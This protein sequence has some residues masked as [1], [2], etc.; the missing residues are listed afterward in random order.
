MTRFGI[1]GDGGSSGTW[2]GDVDWRLDDDTRLH[3]EQGRPA[4]PTSREIVSKRTAVSAAR[5][6]RDAS[7]HPVTSIPKGK[8]LEAYVNKKVSVNLTSTVSA[9][10]G[11]YYIPKLDGGYGHNEDRLHGTH[12]MS[13]ALTAN[14]G[15]EGEPLH[16]AL[17]T[18]FELARVY[19]GSRGERRELQV[20]GKLPTRSGRILE[21][22]EPCDVQEVEQ[23]SFVFHD[24]ASAYDGA[25]RLRDAAEDLGIASFAEGGKVYFTGHPASFSWSYRVF[26]KRFLSQIQSLGGGA[27]VYERKRSTARSA[28]EPVRGSRSD[29]G[30]GAL[31]NHAMSDRLFGTPHGFSPELLATLRSFGAEAMNPNNLLV[32]R[33][34]RAS[35]ATSFVDSNCVGIEVSA[36]REPLLESFFTRGS[37]ESILPQEKLLNVGVCRKDDSTFLIVIYLPGASFALRRFAALAVSSADVA[38]LQFDYRRLIGGKL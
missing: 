1:D 30:S 16:V 21:D 6:Y 25:D 5:A 11:N 10:D 15:L 31:R 7:L 17:G 12:L 22:A 37:F 23:V 20:T 24:Q 14:L 26:E 36:D 18:R 2:D 29:S 4:P 27:P 34:N 13:G 8:D 19:R 32:Q 9:V 35:P 38:C 3:R 28:T 33:Y